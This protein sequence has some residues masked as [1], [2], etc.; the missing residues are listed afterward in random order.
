MNLVEEG[1]LDPD[2][3]GSQYLTRG[4]LQQLNHDSR[5]VIICR[6]FGYTAGIANVGGY[7]GFG[8]K[9]T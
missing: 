5:G 7:S 9:K 1:K 3:P 2:A 6:L 4:K 8:P